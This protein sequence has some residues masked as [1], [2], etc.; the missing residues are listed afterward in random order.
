MTPMQKVDIL[1][2]ACCVAGQDGEINAAERVVIDKL[3]NEVGVGKASLEAMVAR[4]VRDPNFHKE[5]FRVLKSDPQETMAALLEVAMADGE[6]NP[7][8][9]QVLQALSEKLDVSPELFEQLMV[10]VSKMLK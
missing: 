4:G 1:R 8:E 6:I 10:N 2:A 9:K 7:G 3:A 5:Q